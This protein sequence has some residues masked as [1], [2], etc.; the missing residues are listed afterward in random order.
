MADRKIVDDSHTISAKRGNG[1][2]R[3]EIWIDTVTGNVTRYNLAYINHAIYGGDNGRVVGYDNVHAGHHRHYKGNMEPVRF[4]S[5]EH[6]EEQFEQAW[7]AAKD[8]K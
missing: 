8:E 6:T 2:L 1:L 7:L 4:I 5:F 3:R